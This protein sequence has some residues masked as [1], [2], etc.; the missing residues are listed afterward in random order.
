MPTWAGFVVAGLLASLVGRFVEQMAGK[1]QV[2]DL[3]LTWVLIGT[4]AA[5]L[6]WTAQQWAL[7]PALADERGKSSRRSP[8][9]QRQAR[10]AVGRRAPQVA[11]AVVVG[12]V[13]TVL[14]WQVVVGPLSV[15]SLAAKAE[16]ASESGQPV[17]AGDLLESAVESYSTSAIPRLLLGRG[18]LL[19]SRAAS[20]LESRIAGLEEAL[21]VV[22]GAFDRNP[23]D[24]R[25]WVLAGKITQELAALDGARFGERAVSIAE[26]T[27]ALLPGYRDPREQLALTL[28]VAGEFQRAIDV[29]G[30]AKGLAATTD[31]DGVYLDYITA[32]ALVRSGRADEA[33]PLIEQIEVSGYAGAAVLVRDLR[34][35]E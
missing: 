13:A 9:G 4:V 27:A 16:V 6:G 33:E 32:K 8:S 3:A 2:A 22:E 18:L 28:L 25:A 7:D 24:Y 35:A 1:P 19:G 15:S 21:G 26:R 17:R 29:A 34:Q 12:L 30:S 14:W 23:M 31:P 11:I 20:T 10:A 5:I